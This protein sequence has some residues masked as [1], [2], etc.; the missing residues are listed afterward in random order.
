MLA[1]I[2]VAQ[3]DRPQWPSKRMPAQ[4]GLGEMA[5]GPWWAAFVCDGRAG[6]VLRGKRKAREAGGCGR[7]PEGRVKAQRLCRCV[8]EAIVDG[9]CTITVDAS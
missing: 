2:T 1:L 9:P 6:S 8:C 3:R 7:G 4:G 5:L